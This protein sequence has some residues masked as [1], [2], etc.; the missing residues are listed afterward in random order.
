MNIK[1][2]KCSDEELKNEIRSLSSKALELMFKNKMKLLNKVYVTIIIDNEETKKE[3]A[4]GLCSWTDQIHR[5]KRFRI[6]LNDKVS[7][8]FFRKTLLH[9]LVHVKQYIMNELKDCHNGNV[10]WKK[11][12]Y[13]DTESYFEYVNTPWEKQAYAMSEKLYQKL[14]T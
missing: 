7:K 9:E 12:I 8:R 11:K 2:Y 14:C 1:V 3:K 5:P 4:Y 6:T 10:K 13:E